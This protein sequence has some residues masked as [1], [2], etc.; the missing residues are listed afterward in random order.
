ML[1]N[2]GLP[3]DSGGSGERLFSYP[4]GNLVPNLV[5]Q[6]GRKFTRKAWEH[7][8][9]AVPLRRHIYVHVH[10][11][12][13]VLAMSHL[14]QERMSRRRERRSVKLSMPVPAYVVGIHAS[15]TFTLYDKR[16]L[17]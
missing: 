2:W 17:Q 7:L 16:P 4:E 15:Q 8:R 3:A 11:P 9:D 5:S 14:L 12:D 10:V 13:S 6:L 1:L